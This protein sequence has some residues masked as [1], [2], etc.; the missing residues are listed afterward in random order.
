MSSHITN[1]FL[2]LSNV[3]AA[4]TMNL[5]RKA[6]SY[7]GIDSLVESIKSY[8]IKPEAAPIVVRKSDKAYFDKMT[9]EDREANKIVTDP[10]AQIVRGH[11]RLMALRQFHEK[12]PKEFATK[13]PN[14]IPVQLHSDLSDVDM[15]V[16][17]SDDVLKDPMRVRLCRTERYYQVKRLRGTM[18]QQEVAAF[19]GEAITAEQAEKKLVGDDKASRTEVQL[20]ERLTKMSSYCPDI[21][22]EWE[23]YADDTDS[24]EVSASKLNLFNCDR[25]EPLVLKPVEMVL[26]GIFGNA[27]VKEVSL[28]GKATDQKPEVLPITNEVLNSLYYGGMS[29]DIKKHAN[30]ITA[31]KAVFLA[32]AWNEFKRKFWNKTLPGRVKNARPKK[33][34]D[35]RAALV[36][37]DGPA[38]DLLRWCAGAALNIDDTV[39]IALQHTKF[40]QAYPEEFTA[41]VRNGLTRTD[42]P[43]TAIKKAG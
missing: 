6:S 2:A 4:F 12:F 31:D 38:K 35:Q 27:E 36:P 18:S 7:L 11:R 3:F 8:G 39:A 5:R 14:G 43:K 28:K 33:E 9:K 10:K 42:T 22:A 23:R 1:V 34:I 15:L 24:R 32:S 37:V 20:Y 41:F 13:F 17:M 21:L 26:S 30:A 19:L 40:A 25:P 29:E 16:M